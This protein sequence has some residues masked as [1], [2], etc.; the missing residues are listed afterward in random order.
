MVFG[1]YPQPIFTVNYFSES[2]LPILVQFFRENVFYNIFNDTTDGMILG[3]TINKIFI[4]PRC[5]E[6]YSTHLVIPIR[7]SGASGEEDVS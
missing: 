4:L 7:P 3:I 5:A 1:Q 2:D 6:T